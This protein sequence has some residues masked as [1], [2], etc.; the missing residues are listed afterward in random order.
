MTTTYDWITVGIFSG[1]I[2]LFLHRSSTAA[3][4]RD[5]MH[6]YLVALIGCAVANYLGN[7]G[8]GAL[9]AAVIAAVL[10]FILMVLRPFRA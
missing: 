4:V 9:A 10:T 8:Q 2:V 1:L 3:L 5:P 7:V 6:N